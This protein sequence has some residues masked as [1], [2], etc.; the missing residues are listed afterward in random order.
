V[1]ER[2]TFAQT[3]AFTEDI[4]EQVAAYVNAISYGVPY[5]G[6][7]DVDVSPALDFLTA[8]LQAAFSR[9]MTPQQALDTFVQQAN[10]AVFNR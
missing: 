2:L 10:R 3:Q 8:A 1:N 5:Y 4:E 9:Q 7:S 6:P